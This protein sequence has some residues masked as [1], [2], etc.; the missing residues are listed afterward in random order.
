MEEG[1]APSGVGSEE[2]EAPRGVADETRVRSNSRSGPSAAHATPPARARA[3]AYAGLLA[4]W[5]SGGVG[6]R[7]AGSAP[8]K[9]SSYSLGGYAGLRR[10]RDDVPHTAGGDGRDKKRRRVHDVKNATTPRPCLFW[11]QGACTKGDACGY[12]HGDSQVPCTQFASA[13]G[14]RFGDKCAFKHHP[15]SIPRRG[16]ESPK[17]FTK[18]N[19]PNPF[20]THAENCGCETCRPSRYLPV[21]AHCDSDGEEGEMRVVEGNEPLGEETRATGLLESEMS[22]DSAERKKSRARDA[23]LAACAVI[24]SPAMEKTWR[25]FADPEVRRAQRSGPA[26]APYKR[27]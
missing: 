15:G 20:A 23:V 5:A 11:R 3:G 12:V 9:T 14:C 16:L 17:R 1:E 13:S 19:A 24:V 6:A 8:P 18:K 10:G 2:G 21:A 25:A 7:T 26:P 4:G 27:A 22:P